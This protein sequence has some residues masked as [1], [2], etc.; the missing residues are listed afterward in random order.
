MNKYISNEKLEYLSE[1]YNI[2]TTDEEYRQFYG[3]IPDLI[4][5]IKEQQKEIES[6][7]NIIH[8]LQED[9]KAYR[10][11]YEEALKRVNWKLKEEIREINSKGEDTPL[12]NFQR[13]VEVAEIKRLLGLIVSTDI[14][15]LPPETL[16]RENKKLLN[17]LNAIEKHFIQTNYLEA[18]KYSEFLRRYNLSEET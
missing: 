4:S 1:L 15:A 16:R 3:S 12:Q 10:I 2:E 7:E 17:V 5:E 6:L 11:G 13:A 9:Q 14:P 18:F 8:D